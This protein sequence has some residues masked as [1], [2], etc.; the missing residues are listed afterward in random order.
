MESPRSVVGAVME[1]ADFMA[2]S[3]EEF[4]SV[5]KGLGGV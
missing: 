2:Y 5:V 1:D 4:G 3:M